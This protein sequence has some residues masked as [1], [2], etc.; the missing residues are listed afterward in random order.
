MARL[1]ISGDARVIKNRSSEC[2]IRVAN[3]TIL[4]CWQMACRLNN[5]R[6]ARNKLAGMTA[7]A[8]TCNT[9][10]N[11]A[12]KCRRRSKTADSCIIVTLTA[13]CLCRDVIYFLRRCNTRVMTG[14][15]IVVN[16]SRIM[17]EAASK[18]RVIVTGDK[19]TC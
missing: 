13:F 5:Q 14:R 2:Y 11:R 9:W 7:F 6:I 18:S 10:V 16:D 17:V 4:H 1:T 12:Y 15:T 3:V 19:M 8:A